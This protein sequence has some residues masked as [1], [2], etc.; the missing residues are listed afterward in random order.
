[1]KVLQDRL[2]HLP[3]HLSHSGDDTQ[4]GKPDVPLQSQ[5]SSPGPIQV[6]SL[7]KPIRVHGFG[8]GD[9]VRPVR[10]TGI[11]HRHVRFPIQPDL[12]VRTG[13]LA[14]ELRVFEEGSREDG[15]EA[16]VPV[17]H[18]HQDLG[19]L[20]EEAYDLAEDLTASAH[21]RRDVQVWGLCSDRNLCR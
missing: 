2:D 5:R 10:S 15:H 13:E 1:M 14:C 20:A 12:R 17:V 7:V 3:R 18:C 8:P 6:P 21:E 11:M 9:Q 16:A 19:F 4:Y